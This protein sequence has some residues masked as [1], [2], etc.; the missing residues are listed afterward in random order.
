MKAQ[1]TCSPAPPV[2]DVTTGAAPA[3]ENAQVRR[4]LEAGY[5]RYADA[6]KRKDVPAMAA[7][8]TPD[9]SMRMADGKKVNRQETEALL[10]EVAA[11]FPAEPEMTITITGLSVRENKAVVDSREKI[12]GITLDAQKRPHATVIVETY[13]D[14]WTRTRSGWRFSGVELLTSHTTVDGGPAE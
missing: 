10:A 7:M 3:D 14:T 9:F 12:V 6:F 13:R 8:L 1:R 2:S 11:A 5:A 4:A